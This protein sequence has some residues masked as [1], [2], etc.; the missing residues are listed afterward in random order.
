[1]RFCLPS[2]PWSQSTSQCS[3]RRANCSRTSSVFFLR[4]AHIRHPHWKTSCPTC[5]CKVASSPS[6]SFFDS[7]C[8]TWQH[9]CACQG[10]HP[11]LRHRSNMA[12]CL[13]MPRNVIT[14]HPTPTS[15]HKKTKAPKKNTCVSVEMLRIFQK[16]YPPVTAAMWEDNNSVSLR[17]LIYVPSQLQ[18]SFTTLL[19][20]AKKTYSSRNNSFLHLVYIPSKKF[21]GF[22]QKQLLCWRQY[23]NLFKECF[24]LFKQS[25]LQINLCFNKVLH[26]QNVFFFWPVPLKKTVFHWKRTRK[27]SILHRDS[28]PRE[29][30]FEDTLLHAVTFL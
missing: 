7:T 11:N 28:S 6:I 5:S 1:M 20:P 3:N 26:A 22:C 25:C 19:I 30:F 9:V 27:N 24:R 4:S 13:C 16:K 14:S 10:P 21:R 18:L 2:F 23:L 17:G 29:D 8:P 12:T 15:P